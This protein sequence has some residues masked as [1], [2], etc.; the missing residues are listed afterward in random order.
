MLK[1]FD[2][3]DLI[4]MVQIF[5]WIKQKYLYIFSFNDY[6]TLIKKNNC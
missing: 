3:L 4:V 5:F 6:V 1:E 2:V